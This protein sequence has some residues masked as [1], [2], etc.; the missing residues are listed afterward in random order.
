MSITIDWKEKIIY[1]PKEDLTLVQSIPTEIRELNLNWFRLQLKAL[2]DTEVGMFFPDTHI[3]YPEVQVSG[4]ILA[5]VIEIT[6]GYTITF[7]DGQ[8]AVNLTGA[9][10]NVGDYVNVNRVSVRSNNS[11][12]MT[13]NSAIEYASF[14]GGV[15]V[16]INSKYVGT[17]YPVGTPQQPVNNLR[18]ALLIAKY[19]GFTTF[20]IISNIVIEDALNFSSMIFIGESK[21]KTTI[22]ILDSAN[23]NKCEFYEAFVTGVLDGE[24]TLKNCMISDLL[25][26]TGF[27]E[28]CILAPGVIII[29][30]G[31]EATFLNCWSGALNATLDLPLIDMG[32]IGQSLAIRNFN[33]SF[34]I[35]NKRGPE[36]ITIDLNSGNVFADL[37]SMT[38]GLF[39]ITGIGKCM[40]ILT[41]NHV[42][43]GMY[44]NM[45]VLNELISKDNIA[46][47]VWDEPLINHVLIGSTG[48]T[49]S[50]SE[51]KEAVCINSIIGVSGIDLPLVGTHNYPVNNLDDALI[52]NEKY[53]F[54]AFHITGDITLT[55]NLD[56]FVLY[57]ARTFLIDKINL[58]N[59]VLNNVT[60]NNLFIYGRMTGINTLFNNC[61]ISNVTNISG[62]IIGGRMD[63]LITVEPGNILSGVELVI[64]GDNTVIDLQ[65]S[66]NTIVSL[67][68]NSGIITFKNAVENCLIELNLK[69]GEIVLDSSCTGGEFYAEGYGTLYN[70]SNMTVTDNHLLALESLDPWKTELPSAYPSS[71]AGGKLVTINKDVKDNQ[72]IILAK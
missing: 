10:S 9:N 23:V 5:R 37:S 1:I 63:G 32:G 47:A 24:S 45:Q 38:D 57:S 22:H 50:T 52:I 27:I 39:R 17:T 64:E 15:T 58:N 51:F 69:G 43:T 70:E 67:D 35:K 12:G 28:E 2:E 36:A 62:E 3:H 8:Y 16:D 29:G 46:E 72:A 31:S 71:S 56:T 40:D 20:F 49:F 53:K 68:V 7:E 4:L 18:D 21:T 13:S 41:H 54:N 25:Y 34:K 61:Y 44:N 66:Q 19:R 11:A 60:F 6:N 33:G 55:Q 14:N 48:K 30:G 26:I 65:N 42:K 59:R